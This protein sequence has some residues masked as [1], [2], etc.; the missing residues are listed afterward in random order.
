MAAQGEMDKEVVVHRQGY[1]RFITLLRVS[2]AV[3]LVVAF[4]VIFAISN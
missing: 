1:E 3:C 4:I 2:A